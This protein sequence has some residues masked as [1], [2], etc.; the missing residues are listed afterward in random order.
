M[1]TTMMSMQEQIHVGVLPLCNVFW[2]VCWNNIICPCLFFFCI[3]MANYFGLASI[4]HIFNF[5]CWKTS[6]VLRPPPFCSHVIHVIGVP[7]PSPFFATLPLPCIVLNAN[8]TGEIREW[9]YWETTELW[10]WYFWC[11][12]ITCKTL[13]GFLFDL[14]TKLQEIWNGKPEFEVMLIIEVLKDCLTTSVHLHVLS[15]CMRDESAYP[16][17][18]R[19]C[20]PEVIVRKDANTP[21]LL[22]KVLVSWSN[23]QVDKYQTQESGC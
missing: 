4:Y 3:C 10:I 6:L 16:Y 13:P 9:G 15:N 5:M 23:H 18:T 22:P 2:S 8:K 11:H 17:I 12:S 21:L 19:K 7:R 20:L 1:L 14:V